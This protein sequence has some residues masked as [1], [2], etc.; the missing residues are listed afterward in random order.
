MSGVSSDVPDGRP[1]KRPNEESCNQEPL[2]KRNRVA[3]ALALGIQ[4]DWTYKLWIAENEA[5]KN[6]VDCRRIW[7]DFLNANPVLRRWF[8]SMQTKMTRID[9]ST[10][11]LWEQQTKMVFQVEK[12]IISNYCSKFSEFES[13]K[14]LENI[15]STL[16]LK[17]KHCNT[18]SV[19]VYAD[20]LFRR[21]VATFGPS[22]YQNME[23]WFLALPLDEATKHV[24]EVSGVPCLMFAMCVC[25]AT[26]QLDD[27]THKFNLQKIF[28]SIV[29]PSVKCK[30]KDF[31]KLEL[32]VLD[33]LE[34]K[35]HV[36]VGSYAASIETMPGLPE[37]DKEEIL[38]MFADDYPELFSKHFTGF[39]YEKQDKNW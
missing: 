34:W 27:V 4:F 7:T 35:T 11:D 21:L 29:F 14:Y 5:G 19:A 25:L 6:H 39:C 24:A 36:T 31:W 28:N 15:F 30:K 22:A 1:P 32:H 2:E 8:N 17:D 9:T 3:D 23:S 37:K 10:R 26:K 18:M 38:K 16:E 20:V 12:V 13:Q 33:R